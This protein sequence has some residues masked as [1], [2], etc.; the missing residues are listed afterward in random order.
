MSA[1][2]GHGDPRIFPRTM[3][4][5]HAEHFFRKGLACL[6]E[7][8]PADAARQFLTAIQLERGQRIRRP[9][10]RYLSFYGFSLALA[11]GPSAEAL[12]ACETAVRRDPDNPDVRLNLGRVLALAGAR[13]RALACAEAGLARSPG[14]RGLRELRVDLERRRPPAVGFLCRDHPVNRVLGR[15]RSSLRTP[16]AP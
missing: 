5:Q 1:L 9:E 8:H 3:P 13:T 15:L 10:M 2:A 14:H 7:G 16:P 12:R 6:D 11:D 4:L